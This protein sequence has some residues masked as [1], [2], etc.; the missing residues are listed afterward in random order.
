[1]STADDAAD[2]VVA[3]FHAIDDLD[4]AAVTASLTSAVA[5][6]YTSLWGG[7]PDRVAAEQVP[8]A[9]RELLP[10]FDATQHLLG[11]ILATSADA[12]TVHF[13]LNVRGYHVIRGDQPDDPPTATWMVA[14]RYDIDVHR[15]DGAWRIAAITL[16]VS[17]EHGDRSLVDVAHDRVVT[18]TAGRTINPTVDATPRGSANP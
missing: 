9:W 16:H 4:W 12:N 13:D 3:L 15:H 8:S 7:Q 17:Y 6:D 5:I 10:G 2:A 18:H 14:G 1:M 11:P